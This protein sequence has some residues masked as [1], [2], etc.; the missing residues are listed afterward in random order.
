VTL[1]RI[2]ANVID[3][4]IM[5]YAHRADVEENTMNLTRWALREME[6]LFRQYSPATLMN[7]LILGTNE[8]MPRRRED[9]RKPEAEAR[10]EAECDNSPRRT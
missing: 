1:I 4:C 9:E 2:K 5:R 8:P 3:E 7:G 6:S 10:D